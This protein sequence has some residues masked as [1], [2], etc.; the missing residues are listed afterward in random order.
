MTTLRDY[1]YPNISIF[2]PV[3]VGTLIS[4]IDL[5][6]QTLSVSGTTSGV[7]AVVNTLF[8]TS[9]LQVSGNTN[10]NNVTFTGTLPVFPSTLGNTITTFSISALGSTSVTGLS[11]QPQLVYIQA[12]PADQTSFYRFGFGYCDSALTQF[13]T[14]VDTS[15]VGNSF[16]NVINVIN[17]AGTLLCAAQLTSLNSDGFTLNVSTLSGGPYS[18]GCIVWE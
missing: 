18:F 14:F 3:F 10:V 6:C 8:E 1:N 5:S 17:D 16:A 4:C 12:L 7:D 11:F 15:A 9:V 2:I 13:S